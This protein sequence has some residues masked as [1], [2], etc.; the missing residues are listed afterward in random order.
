MS[1]MTSKQP[2]NMANKR[3]TVNESNSANSS[4]SSTSGQK[5]NVDDATLKKRSKNKQIQIFVSFKKC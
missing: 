4:G 1:Q 5:L 2:I 3:N